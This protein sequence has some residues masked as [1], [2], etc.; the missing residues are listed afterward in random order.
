MKIGAFIFYGQRSMVLSPWHVGHASIWAR[1]PKGHINYRLKEAGELLG[2]PV[3]DHPIYCIYLERIIEKEK[4]L[5][6]QQYV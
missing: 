3:V 5:V 6:I 4:E 1:G 2:I